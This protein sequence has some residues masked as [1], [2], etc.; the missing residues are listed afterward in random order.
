MKPRKL[1]YFE[2]QLKVT[3]QG[4]AVLQVIRVHAKEVMYLVQKNRPTMV[5]WQRHHG[6]VFIKSVV[7]SG[8]E[9]DATCIK[10]VK[11]ISMETLLLHMAEVLQ[12]NGS[13]ELKEMIG[14]NVFKVLQIVKHSNSLKSIINQ[15]NY[16]LTTA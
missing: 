1:E 5:C 4:M 16:S 2:D 11:G 15:I 8:F 10:E 13:F 7:D 3:P 9:E 6:P 14:Q 12:D